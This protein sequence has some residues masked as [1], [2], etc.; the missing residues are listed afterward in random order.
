VP[1]PGTLI[2][3]KTPFFAARFEQWDYTRVARWGRPEIEAA[4]QDAGIVRNRLKVEAAVQNAKIAV[5]LDEE[6]P[7]GFLAFLWRHCGSAPEC[8]VPRPVLG[9][10]RWSC[11][12]PLAQRLMQHS[13]GAGHM[14]LNN[15]EDH[16]DADGVHPTVYVSAAATAFKKRG[17]KFL[18]GTTMLSFMQAAGFVNHHKRDCVSF[19]ECER[20]Y[21]RVARWGL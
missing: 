20:A 17:F 13:C 1:S 5:E 14:R 6:E 11:D 7:N 12:V 9:M 19:D 16:I 18:G 15:R 21:T 8:E 4:L 2:H 3:K 10:H